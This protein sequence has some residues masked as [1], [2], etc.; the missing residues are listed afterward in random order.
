AKKIIIKA[1]LKL[2]KS[3]TDPT[4]RGR[5]APPKIPVHKI[6]DNA[7]GCDRTE[8]SAV[9]KIMEYIAAIQKPKAGKA[10]TETLADP[11]IAKASTVAVRRT[12]TR[13]THFALKTRRIPSP[14]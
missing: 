12:S 9:E 5:S 7:P 14:T 2:V 8:L 10:K 13:R 4:I 1:T 6:P 11:Y 3:A